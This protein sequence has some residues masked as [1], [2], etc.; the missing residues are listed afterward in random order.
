MPCLACGAGVADPSTLQ[1]RSGEELL[2]DYGSAA[3]GIYRFARTYGFLSYAKGTATTRNSANSYDDFDMNNVEKDASNN[4]LRNTQRTHE[5]PSISTPASAG[6][7]L[8]SS[9][10]LALPKDSFR[11]RVDSATSQTQQHQQPRVLVVPVLL[12]DATGTQGQSRARAE[13][14]H[15][16]GENAVASARKALGDPPKMM[17]AAP[18]KERSTQAETATPSGAEEG[19]VAAE[20]K[21]LEE[22]LRRYP[23]SVEEDLKLLLRRADD[24][25]VGVEGAQEESATT[26]AASAAVTAEWEDMCIAVR[27]AEKVALERALRERRPLLPL[28]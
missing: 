5:A 16:D 1:R 25:P 28:K 7:E 24:G 14:R 18:A 3:K 15:Y 9:S 26:P 6:S 11:V 10:S 8:P 27:A 22:R 2:I 4:T 17:A 21:A 19:V 12:A 23:T 13:N 20:I